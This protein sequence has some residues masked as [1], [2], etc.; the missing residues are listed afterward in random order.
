MI[1]KGSMENGLLDALIKMGVSTWGAC[2]K[3]IVSIY[4]LMVAWGGK[5]GVGYEERD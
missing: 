3:E 2:Y 5:G 1:Q 4:T